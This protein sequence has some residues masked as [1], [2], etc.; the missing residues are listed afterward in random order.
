MHSANVDVPGAGPGAAVTAAACPFDRG[1]ERGIAA[2]AAIRLSYAGF[3][4]TEVAGKAQPGCALLCWIA[5]RAFQ[6]G[7]ERRIASGGRD[8]RAGGP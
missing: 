5:A 3:R 8:P 4:D 7:D 1:D 6:R 2:V